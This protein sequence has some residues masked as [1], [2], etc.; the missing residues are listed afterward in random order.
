VPIDFEVLDDGTGLI[1]ICRGTLTGKDKIDTNERLLA[2]PE[3]L[4]HLKYFLIDSESA[5]VDM[6]TSDLRLI[7]E[8]D[9]RIAAIAPP[10]LAVAI[11]ASRDADFGMA[12]MWQVFV[13]ETDWDT[14]VCRSFKEAESWLREKLKATHGSEFSNDSIAGFDRRL[15]EQ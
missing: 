3:I 12:R 11:I 2:S 8:Q 13:E 9:R 4:K 1:L 6:S 7:A 5:A 15:K 10:G 14:M